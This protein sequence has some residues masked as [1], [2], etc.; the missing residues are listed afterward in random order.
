L[1][2]PGIVS[3]KIFV[4]SVDV[5]GRTQV[6]AEG[7]GTPLEEAPPPRWRLLSEVQAAIE[8]GEIQDAKTEIALYRF[9]AQ[10]RS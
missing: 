7:D 6:E 2:A 3:E 10:R 4:C 9:L 8:K 1:V 5:T